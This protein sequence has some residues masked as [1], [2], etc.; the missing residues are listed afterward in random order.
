MS[1]E[2]VEDAFALS[3]IQ[4][5]ML[6]D[7]L[8][9]PDSDVYVTYVTI[10]ITGNVDNNRLQQAWTEVF[11]RHQSLRAAFYWDGLDEPLQVIVADVTHVWNTHSWI[12][13]S[14]ADQELQMQQLLQSERRNK[15]DLS[16]APLSRFNFVELAPGLS[17]LVWT[18]HHLLADGFST[19]TILEDVLTCYKAL[20]YAMASQ[21][22]DVYQ[23]SQYIRWLSAQ[24][25]DKAEAFWKVRLESSSPTPTRLRR[26]TLPSPVSETL[27][28][29][30]QVKFDVS[31]A[32]TQELER[33]CQSNRITLS[34]F[35]HG[36]WAL[37]LREYSGFP[38]SLFAS[39]VSGRHADI[40]GM[41]RAVG[42]YLNAQ[43]R[44]IDTS[45]NIPLVQWLHKVQ[46]D[47]HQ[48]AKYDY[49]SL[50]K[51]QGL[52][53]NDL[54][55]SPF[56]SIITIGGHPSELDITPDDQG[57]TFTN[58]NYQLMQSH[59]ALAFL[60]FPGECLGMSIVFDASRYIASDVDSMAQYLLKLIDCMLGSSHQYPSAITAQCSMLENDAGVVANFKYD[61]GVSRTTHGWFEAV[62][63]RDPNAI[64]L[65]FSGRSMT[66]R[67]L[68]EKANQVAHFIR[69]KTDATDFS[70]IG[71]MLPRS[72]DQLAGILGI[73]KSGHA[74]VPIDPEFPGAIIQSYITT[75]K[76]KYVVSSDDCFSA[77]NLRAVEC[78]SMDQIGGESIQRPSGVSRNAHELAYVMFTSGSTGMP[79][80][81]QITHENLIYST[82]ARLAYYGDTKPVYLLL[83]SIAFD[84]SVAG[85]YWTLCAGGT[86]VLPEPS[87][88][89]N[90]QSIGELVQTESVT[91]TL[92]LPSYYQLLI[93]N[94]ASPMLAN[95]SVV[96]VA[97]EAC[98]A[99]LVQQH[100][101]CL[102]ATALFNEYGPTEACVWSS[103]YQFKASL[104]GDVPIGVAVGTTYLQVVNAHGLPCPPGV[105]GE[106]V[107]GGTGVSPGYIN[108]L[109]A[110]STKFVLSQGTVDNNPVIY[111]TGD[112]AY[113]N[114]NGDLVFTGRLDRQLKIRGHR[115]EPGA[116]ESTL[117][118]HEGIDQSVVVALGQEALSAAPSDNLS[119][120]IMLQR[121]VND[122]SEADVIQALESLGL[123]VPVHNASQDGSQ[124]T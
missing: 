21:H 93:Q 100:F 75:A 62:A 13:E 10:D 49:S 46:L 76:I 30:P 67:A 116:V 42:L 74:Y 78:L 36:A 28:N 121:L 27:S 7:S 32:K 106:I 20:P 25:Q 97:G 41:D 53:N 18:V 38:S 24:N 45:E 12:G 103:V 8:A 52:I 104:T 33:F 55:E 61:N 58:I 77:A 92:C 3:P 112:L 39:T 54:H 15:F 122:F 83:S 91:H 81:V 108:D 73:L 82:E 60:V 120:E 6:F 9:T 51:I 71:L 63:D 22:D 59:Y 105:E 17:R 80:G 118:Q 107:I 72:T 96:I 50:G 16:T 117:N 113:R 56:E 48:C 37:L 89:K 35:L 86:L 88:E 114:E 70:P 119:R 68:D 85:I 65:R 11:K 34:T 4:T 99:E 98:K 31:V 57:V 84:S 66:Y 101:A 109:E 14:C 44:F 94:V 1:L 123:G 2:N 79:K 102:P 29:I 64:A 23:Y 19:P 26:Q 115:I 47:I 110:S 40:S 124:R 5:G 95:L 69:R 90:I 111:K 43:P 87:E